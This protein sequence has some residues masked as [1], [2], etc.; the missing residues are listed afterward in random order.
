MKTKKLIILILLAILSGCISFPRERIDVKRYSINPTSDSVKADTS[1]DFSVK[2]VPFDASQTYKG[3]RIIYRDEDE[4]MNYY[5]Y[6]RW[7]APPEKMLFEV[8]A[9]NLFQWGLFDGGVFQRDIGVAPTHEIHGK[10]TH[11]YANNIHNQYQAVLHFNL[12]VLAVEP[13]TYKKTLI[14]QKEYRL[15]RERKNSSIKSFI[16]EVNLLAG[17]WLDQVKSDLEL[18]FMEEAIK[19]SEPY[20]REDIDEKGGE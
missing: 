13:T 3:D 9:A 6:N 19:R 4:E 11:L 10:V 20:I 2:I 16:E 1:L 17:D 14:F 15:F 12:I 7:I 18:V 5:Y 8:F